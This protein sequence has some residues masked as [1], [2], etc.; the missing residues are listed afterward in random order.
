MSKVTD[1]SPRP[2]HVGLHVYNM[3]ESIEW[4]V[5]MFGFDASTSE[6][7]ARGGMFPRMKMIHLGDFDIEVYEVMNPLAYDMVDYEYKIGLK[8]LGFTVRKF[9]EWVKYAKSRGVEF[10]YEKYNAD[11]SNVFVKD[12]TGVLVEVSTDPLAD[13]PT[14][15][16]WGE[17][18]I[19]AQHVALH[20]KN[21]EDTIEWYE[22]AFGFEPLPMKEYNYGKG[23]LAPKMQEIILRGFVCELY[24]V[25]TAEPFTYFD[26]EYSVGYKHLDIGFMD[27]EGW[28]K[29]LKDND[30]PIVFKVS[31]GGLPHYALDNNNMLIEPSSERYYINRNSQK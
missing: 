6:L 24:E 28:T 19:R 10:V 26:F 12:N 27:L 29:F 13:D 25:P 22:A 31:I 1:F 18:G 30:V 8:H 5:D 16:V 9:D 17:L 3:E 14:V 11:H 7:R 4:Y 20:V 21:I 23:G 2:D 15:P